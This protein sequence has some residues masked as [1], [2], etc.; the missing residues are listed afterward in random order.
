MKR[1]ALATLT[2]STFLAG[3]AHSQNWSFVQSVGGILV[4]APLR[5]ER[6]WVLPVRANVAG[7]EEFS[8]KPTMVNSALHCVSTKASIE[9][10]NIYL[11]V[12]TFVVSSGT[13]SRCPPAV[14]GKVV[15]GTYKVFYRGPGEAPVP[16]SQVG[17]W[18]QLTE[19]I[20]QVLV[21]RA[22][23]VEKYTTE[24]YEGKKVGEYIDDVLICKLLCDFSGKIRKKNRILATRSAYCEP[25][26][27]ESRDTLSKIKKQIP[28]EYRRYLIYDEKADIGGSVSIEFSLSS[29]R[30][31]E[32]EEEISRI[33]TCLPT[34]F[35]FKEFLKIAKETGLSLDFE[36]SRIYT[37]GK[38]QNFSLIFFNR[39]Y[40]SINKERIYTKLWHRSRNA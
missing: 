21:V 22:I 9:E 29:E 33:K 1:I 7:I 18:V 3:C 35:T 15:P 39:L 10:N 26:D 11:T 20:G 36:S 14:L 31:K 13:D 27:R 38:G 40:K 24:Y 6:G 12:R 37:P 25:L 17:Q 5:D 23:H 19:G 32:V 28:D 34:S 16:L 2:A 8:N 30:I 4:E